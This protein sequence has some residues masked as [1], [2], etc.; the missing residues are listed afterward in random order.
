MD[1]ASGRSISKE[2]F[3]LMAKPMMPVWLYLLGGN[4]GWKYKAKKNGVSKRINE[5][6]HQ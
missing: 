2:A 1:I 3:D 5:C 6:P 4:W